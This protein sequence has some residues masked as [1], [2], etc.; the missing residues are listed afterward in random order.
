MRWPL[1]RVGAAEA[2]NLTVLQQERHAVVTTLL[3]KSKL[4]LS[5]GSRRA[6]TE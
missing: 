3:Q 2:H 6:K 5:R 1:I 4:M